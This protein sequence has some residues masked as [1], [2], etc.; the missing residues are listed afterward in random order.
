MIRVAG[1]RTGVEIWGSEDIT[2]IPMPQDGSSL[3]GGMRIGAAFAAQALDGWQYS[4]QASQ[5]GNP[6]VWTYTI[7][8]V[9]PS[10]AEG[11]IAGQLVMC[12]PTP[13]AIQD[14]QAITS[15]LS[16]LPGASN[17]DIGAVVD[18]LFG[19]LEV[20]QERWRWRAN[21]WPTRFRLRRSTNGTRFLP[22]TLLGYAETFS[23]GVFPKG[24]PSPASRNQSAIQYLI[25]TSPAVG[26]LQTV[27]VV[28][29]DPAT[30]RQT[31]NA[32]PGL[33]MDHLIPPGRDGTWT[34]DRVDSKNSNAPWNAMTA[35]LI[36]YAV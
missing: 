24:T 23:M 26:T 11:A 5:A 32:I 22:S 21:R 18:R 17:L 34:F 25:R 33:L 20:G 27:G 9:D 14:R 8:E 13:S 19:E 3:D 15:H 2:F 36:L 7:R 12:S 10:G 29:T 1:L 4:N 28:E 16:G 6:H 30:K 31:W 35:K